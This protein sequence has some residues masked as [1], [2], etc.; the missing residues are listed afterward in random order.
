ML[1][2]MVAFIIIILV[3]FF[4]LQRKE[5]VSLDY[6]DEYNKNKESYLNYYGETTATLL[7]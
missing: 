2:K 6:Y 4:I 5:E 3:S 1:F 7:N